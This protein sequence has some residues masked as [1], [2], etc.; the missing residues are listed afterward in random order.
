ML[1]LDT[2][3]FL[4][5]EENNPKIPAQ[6][7]DEILTDNDVFISIA[8][9]WEIAIKCSMGKLDLRVPIDELMD[10]CEFPILP[11]R[12]A[13]LKLLNSLPWIHRD[14][15][16]RLLICQAQAEGLTLVS[17]DENIRKYDVKTLWKD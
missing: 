17:A 12:T 8:S 10:Q 7:M 11:I 9:F 5:F 1:L 13:H 14:P 3:T 4:W 16:D 15:F 2:H 6:V